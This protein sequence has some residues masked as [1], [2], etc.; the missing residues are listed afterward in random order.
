LKSTDGTSAIT[1]SS[2][3]RLRHQLAA[4][5][6]LA[7]RPDERQ[8]HVEV[9]VAGVPHLPDRVELERKD[10]RV[11]GVSQSAAEPDHRVC[12]LGLE[13]FAAFEA[14]ELVRAE[15]DRPVG[16]RSWSEARRERRQRG[17]HPF[18]EL[19]APALL[20]EQTRVGTVE[21][22]EHHEFG[23]QQPDP[24]DVERSGAFDL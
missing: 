4:P 6:E 22:L 16:D 17:R 11:A 3:P 12:L 2:Q 21:R 14:T 10:L 5:R 9:G 15:V 20:D 7:C 23:A 24:L 1:H 8:H 18:G 13:P 19:R